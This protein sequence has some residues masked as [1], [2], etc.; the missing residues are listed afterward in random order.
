MAHE[1]MKQHVTRALF[2]YW[3]ALRGER[4]AP[5]RADIDAGAIRSSLANTFI[6]TFDPQ[7]G[8]PFRIA[9][10]S[11]YDMF[12]A[13]LTGTP[14]AALWAADEQLA[15]SDLVRTL[16]QEQ[17][18]VVAGVSGRNAEAQTAELE[19]ILLPLTSGDLGTGRI[20]GALTPVSAPYWLSTRPLETLRLGD[21]RFTG[22]RGHD[23]LASVRRVLQGPGFA[24]YP[25]A[26]SFTA[27]LRLTR[28]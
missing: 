4:P 9:G 1:P 15:M 13:E 16:A 19:M 10:T 25:A 24:V 12:G 14:F 17:D 2:D 18:G 8:H 21:L 6:L 5:D 22:A 20:L 26:R 11:L 23:R 3:D 27:S 28:R 7:Q